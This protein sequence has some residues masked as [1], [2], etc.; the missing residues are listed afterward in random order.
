M[1]DIVITHYGLESGLVY[2][3]GRALRAQQK[4]LQPLVLTLDLLPD[5]TVQELAVRLKPTKSSL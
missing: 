1:G 2:K 5:V 3:Q 4:K